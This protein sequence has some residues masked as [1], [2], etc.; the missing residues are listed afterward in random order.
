MS[1]TKKRILIRDQ[2]MCFL[3]WRQL[4]CGRRGGGIGIDLLQR[5][6]HRKTGARLREPVG[7]IRQGGIGQEFD[8]C[9]GLVQ[10]ARGQ[11]CFGPRQNGVGIVAVAR[12]DAVAGARGVAVARAST[13]TIVCRGA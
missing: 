2:S 6:H 7:H 10:L 8:L 11:R 9:H 1:A 5:G 12:R 13:C 4:V 3:G